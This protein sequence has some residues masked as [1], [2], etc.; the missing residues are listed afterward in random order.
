MVLPHLGYYGLKIVYGLKMTDSKARLQVQRQREPFNSDLAAV[1][2]GL[3]EGRVLLD[4]EIDQH[5]V[6][7]SRLVNKQIGPLPASK[8]KV[9]FWRRS[10]AG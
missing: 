5:A 10:T 1:L 4:P 2:Y 6:L 3:S 7:G 8:K 9:E